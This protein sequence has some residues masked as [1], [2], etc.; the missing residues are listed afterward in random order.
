MQRQQCASAQAGLATLVALCAQ[1]QGSWNSKGSARLTH[2]RWPCMC[3]FA[4]Q[5][6]LRTAL[7]KVGP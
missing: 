2:G 5:R 4:K 3:G 1:K 6:R 7:L